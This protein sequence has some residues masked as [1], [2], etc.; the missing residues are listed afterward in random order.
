MPAPVEST[1]PTVPTASPELPQMTEEDAWHERLAPYVGF[2]RTVWKREC[3]RQHEFAA[4]FG[5]MLDAL[6]DRI[7]EIAAEC[8]GDILIEDVGEGYVPIPDYEDLLEDLITS[9]EASGGK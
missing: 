2:L 4:G 9:I 5:G 1:V 6:A 8:M 7:N 3:S